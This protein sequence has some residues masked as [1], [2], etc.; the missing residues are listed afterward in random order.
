MRITTASSP[1]SG[2]WTSASLPACQPKGVSPSPDLSLP[3]EAE[4]L[5]LTP[6]GWWVGSQAGAGEQQKKQG[7]GKKTNQ[8]GQSQPT[9]AICMPNQ[10]ILVLGAWPLFHRFAAG[11][12]FRRIL[13]PVLGFGGGL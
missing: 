2:A 8:Q 7:Q 6:G 12:G 3:R 1:S 5:P 10:E 4:P 9:N 13:L 11:E